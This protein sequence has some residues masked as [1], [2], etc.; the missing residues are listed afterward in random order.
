MIGGYYDTISRFEKKCSTGKYLFA[1]CIGTAAEVGTVDAALSIWSLD[2]T[3]SK[4]ASLEA[5]TK[6]IPGKI[7]D[8]YRVN[9][10]Y[11]EG[12]MWPRFDCDTD[13]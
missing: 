2:S 10:D 4:I 5:C 13:T 7:G 3:S 8:W 12:Y 6:V 9:F 11:E 1:Q